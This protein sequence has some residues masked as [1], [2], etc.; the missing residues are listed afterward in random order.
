VPDTTSHVGWLTELP[1]YG[2]VWLSKQR[3]VA[4]VW[5]R[6]R[7]SADS[8][9]GSIAI[10]YTDP[11]ADRYAIQRWIVD[12]NGCGFDGTLCISP[13]AN[14]TADTA[15]SI[16]EINQRIHNIESVLIRMEDSL[17]AIRAA[18]VPAAAPSDMYIF[19][20]LSNTGTF[21]PRQVLS[22]DFSGNF[23][24]QADTPTPEPEATP[25]EA[26]TQRKIIRDD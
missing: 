14:V 19:G 16:S 7:Q 22:A 26:D 24:D 9:F 17:T 4:T 8:R 12:A 2:Q 10:L 15:V 11:N 21:I 1:P 25:E 3:V 5:D 6:Y 23:S 13:F 18:V 20:P